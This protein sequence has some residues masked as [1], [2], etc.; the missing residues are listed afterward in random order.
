VVA[1][2]NN[3]CLGFRVAGVALFPMSVGKLKTNLIAIQIT[4]ITNLKLNKL[5]NTLGL[6]IISKNVRIELI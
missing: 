1:Q 3:V 2:I 5:N 6:F 4:H